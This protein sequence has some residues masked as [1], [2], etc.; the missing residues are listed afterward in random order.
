MALNPGDRLGPYEISAPIGAGGMGEVYRAFDTRLNRS[1][2]IKVLPETATSSAERARLQREA[3]AVAALSHPNVLAVFDVG[4]EGETFF[5]VTE[6]LEGRS[7][8]DHL[9]E[10]ALPVA[11]AVDF[12]R[13]AAAALHAAHSKGVI[14]RDIK[15]ENLFVTADGR[16]KVLDFGLARLVSHSDAITAAHHTQLTAP[17]TVLG[18]V[19]YMSPEQ[20][21]GEA[22]DAR[23]DIFSLGCVLF[24]MLSGRP[25]FQRVSQTATIAAILNDPPDYSPMGN[26]P[27]RLRRV[28]ERCLAKNAADR[29]QTAEALAA[30]LSVP[31]GDNDLA[32]TVAMK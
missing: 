2:A 9:R 6:L 5:I 30:D 24:E 22:V 31:S 4:T 14:H 27:P 23:S 11:T 25:P 28:I 18:T 32:P 21:R 29:Y 26:V 12:G 16:L 13:Q 3:Q 7:L 17:D 20:V 1:V 10:G 8:R 19:G 15:P